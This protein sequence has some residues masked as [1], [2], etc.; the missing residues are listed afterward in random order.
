MSATEKEDRNNAFCASGSDIMRNAMQGRRVTPDMPHLVPIL[1][2]LPSGSIV[3]EVG[4][5]PGGITLD[6]AQR[7]P[8]LQVLGM[9]IDKQ[10][11]KVGSDLGIHVQGRC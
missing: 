4:C 10:S 9:D 7:Y 11:I 1:E 2:A 5:G 3:C 8:Q 6:I